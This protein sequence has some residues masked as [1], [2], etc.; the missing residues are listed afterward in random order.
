M[1]VKSWF[2][3]TDDWLHVTPST[4]IAVNQVPAETERA[5]HRDIE[6]AAHKLLKEKGKKKAHVPRETHMIR[7]PEAAED[8]Y[9]R[10]VLCTK[11]DNP[12]DPEGAKKGKV[13]CTSPVFRIASTSMDSSV[14]R[15]APLKAL[16]LEVGVFAASMVASST[17]DRF[18]SPVKEPVQAVIDRVRP[19]FVAE[20]VG[21][22]VRDELSDMKEEKEIE[23]YMTWQ[24]AH[25]EHINRSLERD[26]K[27]VEPIGPDTGPE[28]PFPI[29]FHG[30]VVRGTG[31]STAELGIPTANLSNIP[32]EIQYRLRGIYFGW[33]KIEG[34]SNPQH[35]VWHEAIIAVTPCPHAKP[36]VLP[37]PLVAVHIIQPPIPKGDSLVGTTL[38]TILM[39]VLRPAPSPAEALHQTREQ[40]LDQASQDVCLTLISLGGPGRQRGWTAEAAMWR[41]QE[42]KRE[43]GYVDRAERKMDKIGRKI[44][45]PTVPLHKVGVRD[46]DGAER[47]RLL[48]TGGYW[49]KRG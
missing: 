6:K 32:E 1:K 13:L 8:G 26:P 5:W 9:F 24:T 41:L 30:K 46:D 28:Y 31:R 40:K 20:T 22:L 2:N 21:G 33:V 19:G 7:I 3:L 23:E 35:Q 4:Q 43:M 45:I 29:K 44:P 16:P 39:G 11:G 12:Y 17:I 10:V 36:S 49:V 18:T 14:F 25:Q 48:G 47:D 34:Y 42:L 37:K 38:T 27:S 15:G